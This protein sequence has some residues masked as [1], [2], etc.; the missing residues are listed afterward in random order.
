MHSVPMQTLLPLSSLPVDHAAQMHAGAFIIFNPITNAEYRRPPSQNV[1]PSTREAELEAAFIRSHAARIVHAK[2]RRQPQPLAKTRPKSWKFVIQRRN[3]RQSR[4]RRQTLPPLLAKPSAPYNE[5]EGELLLWYLQNTALVHGNGDKSA[6]I[7]WEVTAPQMTWH[8]QCIKHAFLAQAHAMKVYTSRGW[9]GRD[10][11][12]S[13][14]YQNLAVQ[15]LTGD[16]VDTLPLLIA[17]LIF[18]VGSMYVNEWGQA[19]QH[20]LAVLKLFDALGPKVSHELESTLSYV[21][22]LCEDVVDVWCAITRNVTQFPD[23][24][25][26]LKTMGQDD[27]TTNVNSFSEGNATTRW[28]RKMFFD[29]LMALAVTEQNLH[30]I[31]R[32]LEY[33]DMSPGNQNLPHTNLNIAVTLSF[34]MST[35]T[36]VAWLYNRWTSDPYQRQYLTN[37]QRRELLHLATRLHS[38]DSLHAQDNEF[39]AYLAELVSPIPLFSEVNDVA[40]LLEVSR[41]SRFDDVPRD[42]NYTDTESSHR[43]L[44]GPREDFPVLSVRH[45]S[46][47]FVPIVAGRDPRL[48]QDIWEWT[49]IS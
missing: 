39:E 21:R 31:I 40:F 49:A 36:K 27:A 23:Q 43:T 37:D 17:A 12:L 28:S 47:A 42:H 16:S 26:G 32:T 10:Y 3:S 33:P 15:E 6:R 14:E 34:A 19:Y 45:F 30:Y 11:C 20:S 41:Q 46:Y 22:Q 38:S 9:G 4:P 5:E 24:R 8:E 29:T 1:A 44:L 13:L 7:F 2:R 35:L 25:P 18:G 48:R